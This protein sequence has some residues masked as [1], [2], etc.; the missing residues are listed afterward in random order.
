MPRRPAR[1]SKDRAADGVQVRLRPADPFD[2][3]RWLARSQ[4]DPR[5]A[6]AELVQNSLDAGARRVRVERR[7]VKGAPALSVWDDGEG[8][9][10]AFGREDALRY[11]ASHIGHSRKL[12]LTPVERRDRVIAGKYGVGLL[13]F[14]SVGSEFE[15]RSRVAGSGLFA[16]RLREDERGGQIVRLPL[17]IDTPETF[18]EVVVT[19]VHDSVLRSIGGARLASYLGSELRG[20]LLTRTV[21]LVIH[22]RL[23]RGLAQQRFDVQPRRYLGEPLRLPQELALPDQAPARL[24]LYLARGADSPALQ[25][26]CAGT[27]V[28]DDF[29]ELE[30][31]GLAEPPWIDSGLTGVIDAPDLN[32]PPGTRRGVVPDDTA[33]RFADALR[34]ELAPLV[35]A[36][37][38]RLEREQQ[39][40]AQRDVARDLGKALR[41]LAQRLPQYELPGARATNGVAQAIPE[42]PGDGGAAPECT[43]GPPDDAEDT[44]QAELFSA[45]PL[46]SVAIIPETVQV[47]TGGER[48]LRLLASD[49]AER[50]IRRPLSIEWQ[51]DGGEWLELRGDGRRPALCARAD[52]PVGA[53]AQVLVRASE[54]NLVAAA[55]AAVQVVEP[56]P[57]RRSQSAI[58][59]PEFVVDQAG[60]WRSRLVGTRWQVNEAHED[61]VA[62]RGEPRARLRYLLNLFAKEMV[63]RSFSMPGSEELLERMVEVLAHAERNLRGA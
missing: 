55:T 14:W 51:L 3:I 4:S 46:S 31:I 52:A 50:P 2:L 32:V 41:G 63:N 38:E 48:R 23:A 16:L 1:R 6:I 43:E 29:R 10:P 57:E 18:T 13:G 37:L 19:S 40:A 5:K 62:L 26:A 47:P 59:E 8:V 49:A 15:L 12:N 21:E 22:D 24:E 28:A 61:F 45:G 7:R 9:L 36:E 25:L 27:V 35:M 54:G 11:I 39:V 60:S 44:D 30:A 20:Q 58:P 34:R 42:H 56:Q 33:Q 17:R 53:E